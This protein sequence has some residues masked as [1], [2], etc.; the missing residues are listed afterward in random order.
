MGKRFE[1]GAS[2][3]KRKKIKKDTVKKIK[4]IATFLHQ[5]LTEATGADSEVGASTPAQD[6]QC[7]EFDQTT[8][9]IKR[10][11]S[12]IEKAMQDVEQQ[13]GNEEAVMPSENENTNIFQNSVAAKGEEK[14]KHQSS[15]DSQN[16]EIFPGEVNQ[17]QGITDTFADDAKHRCTHTLSLKDVGL[18]K[19]LSNEEIAYWRE[20]ERGPSEV[21]HSCGTIF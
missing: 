17:S 20:R 15:G 8:A 1:S 9:S 4:P 10:E 2:K 16:F 12:L 13:P 21:Q 7:D 5:T 6:N 3:R 14:E 11:E 18:W 19:E